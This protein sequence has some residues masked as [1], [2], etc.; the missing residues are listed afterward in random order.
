ML[1][2]PFWDM[3]QYALPEALRQP[4]WAVATD[5]TYRVQRMAYA[6]GAASA[7]IHRNVAGSWIRT[8]WPLVVGCFPGS[9][10]HEQ[11]HSERRKQL[12]SYLAD[13]EVAV[14]AGDMDTMNGAQR[15]T[16]GRCPT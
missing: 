15:I 14:V 3:L 11:L 2:L 7:V 1:V 9:E 12:V 6:F 4:I 13:A 10:S 8:P 5:A 16:C